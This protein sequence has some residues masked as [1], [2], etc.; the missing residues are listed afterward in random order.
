MEGRHKKL[1]GLENNAEYLPS[2]EESNVEGKSIEIDELEDNQFEREA[3]LV[4][5]LSSMGLCRKT[6][7]NQLATR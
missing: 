6:T 1:T 4:T 3:I 7:S 2:F 5:C